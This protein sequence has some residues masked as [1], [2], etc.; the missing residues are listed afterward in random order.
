V[1][2]E[3]PEERLLL[4]VVIPTYNETRRLAVPLRAIAE[5]LAG[6][7]HPVEIVIADDGSTDGTFEQ[8]QAL[9]AE[10][11]VPVR[12]V[13]YERNRGKGYALK[14]GF[15]HARG[16]RILFTDIDLATPF[17]EL[18]ALEAALGAGC[19]IAVGSRKLA[20]AEIR[21]HQPWLRERM[22]KVFTW[23]VRTFLTDV[24]D[25]T[26][27]FKLFRGDVGREL[28]A[29]LR[30]EDWAFD[31]ELLLLAR[32]RGLRVVEVPVRWED[33]PGTKV[34]LLRDAWSSL[35]GLMRISWYLRRGVYDHPAE[36]DCELAIWSNDAFRSRPPAGSFEVLQ[37]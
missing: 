27:G 12:A 1:Q 23:L 10:W 28:F 13:R 3:T 37:R 2:T 24:S 36:I 15:A 22:G 6:L 32:R 19:D 4:S 14:V 18:A 11:P 21:V 26:C 17:D 20:G 7:G 9:A 33:Q 29:H 25:A 16:E 30:I 34:R 8:I 31:A 35:V 5:Q